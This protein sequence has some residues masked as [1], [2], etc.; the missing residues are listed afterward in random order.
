M[1]ALPQASPRR[2]LA[3]LVVAAIIVVPTLWIAWSLSVASEVAGSNRDQAATLDSLKTRLVALTVGQGAA[4]GATASVFLPGA[5]PAIA[6]AALQRIVADTVEGA[7]GQIEESEI[8][9]SGSEPEEPGAINLRVSFNADLPALQ[10]VIFELETRAPIL[11]ME[12]ISIEANEAAAA[13]E[14]TSPT[15]NVVLLVRGHWEA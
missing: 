14:G 12:G 4:E 8:S 2:I 1:A 3:L 15:L 13:G 10:R 11:A 5:T 7:G 9:R 6:G